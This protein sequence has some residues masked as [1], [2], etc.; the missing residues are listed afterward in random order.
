MQC[1]M[2]TYNL[3][4]TALIEKMVDI[5]FI[6]GINQSK[7]LFPE[8][9]GQRRTATSPQRPSDPHLPGT[10]CRSKDGGSLQTDVR[11][12]L[13]PE[14]FAWRHSKQQW[15]SHCTDVAALS[16]DCL[17][18]QKTRGGC[19]CS[20]SQHLQWG[21]H[22]TCCHHEQ[23]VGGCQPT[24]TAE[25]CQGWWEEN[26][27]GGCCCH[28]SVSQQAKKAGRASSRTASSRG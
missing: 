10:W 20:G 8:S 14:A 2:L 19:C 22:R 17:H 1:Q 12:Q 7:K 15:V 9:C 28:S 5:A 3:P 27:Q 23:V 13:A 25:T 24:H 21:G 18:G 26:E 4:T 11:S 16:Q 6:L